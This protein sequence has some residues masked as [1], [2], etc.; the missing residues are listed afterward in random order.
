MGGSHA[1]YEFREEEFP[2]EVSICDECE[3]ED[4]FED[5]SEDYLEEDFEEDFEENT[6]LYQAEFQNMRISAD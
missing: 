2:A 3:E 5:C 6:D 1:W 4:Y